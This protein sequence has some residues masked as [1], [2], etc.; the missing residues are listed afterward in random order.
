MKCHEVMD[1]YVKLDFRKHPSL[2]GIILQKVLRSSPATGLTSKVQSVEK[3]VNA[4]AESIA[5]LKSRVSAV[6][7]KT[8]KLP[9]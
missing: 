3:T 9:P 6:E 5:S 4:V 1:E 2:N 7:T 8:S